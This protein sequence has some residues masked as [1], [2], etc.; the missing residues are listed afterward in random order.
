MRQ[1]RIGEHASEIGLPPADFSHYCW[2]ERCGSRWK[3]VRTVWCRPAQRIDFWYRPAS[4]GFCLL[5]DRF[6]LARPAIK[7]E[8]TGPQHQFNLRQGI[9]KTLERRRQPHHISHTRKIARVLHDTTFADKGRIVV[10][11]N[12]ADCPVARSRTCNAKDSNQGLT[13]R[14][15]SFHL[16]DYLLG[17]SPGIGVPTLPAPI[18]KRPPAPSKRT[19]PVADGKF[20][21]VPSDKCGL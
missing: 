13:G 18:I 16:F 19:R 4:N 3:K 21:D 17:S 2:R 20:Q 1:T 15:V 9:R 11:P 8:G 5:A 10:A 6:V 7:I 14:N 12:M